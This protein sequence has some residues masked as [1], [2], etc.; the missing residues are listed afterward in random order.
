M[1]E[2]A[3]DAQR[4]G[5]RAVIVIAA[6]AIGFGVVV[7]V[8]YL[9]TAGDLSMAEV[10][11]WDL[12]RR[13]LG[14][15]VS[16]LSVPS[17]TVMT[18]RYH[19]GL[20]YHVALNGWMVFGQSELALRSFTALAG[21]GVLG[22][23]AWVSRRA[24][25]TVAAML[26]ALAA[27][28]PYLVHWSVPA[29]CYGL[30][31]L[32]TVA[33]TA[34]LLAMLRHRRWAW[35]YAGTTILLLHTHHWGSLL[36]AAQSA[37]F[38]VWWLGRLVRPAPWKSWIVC[39]A[40]C[41]VSL[42]PVWGMLELQAETR[43]FG[44]TI[45]FELSTLA[46]WGEELVYLYGRLLQHFDHSNL[47]RHL[48]LDVALSA[49]QAALYLAGLVVAFRRSR[50]L[51]TLALSVLTVPVFL[52]ALLSAIHG[53]RVESIRYFL[54]MAPMGFF[55]WALALDELRRARARFAPGLSAIVLGLLVTTGGCLTI[56]AMTWDTPT[57]YQDLLAGPGDVVRGY[58][59]WKMATDWR[60]L[61]D[62]LKET[63]SGNHVFLVEIG[64][65]AQ[66]LRYYLP[67]ERAIGLFPMR[68]DDPQK[69]LDENLQALGLLFEEVW[70]VRMRP[71]DRQQ[72]QPEAIRKRF[73]AVSTVEFGTVDV[74]HWS[75]NVLGERVGSVGFST[76]FD[77]RPG[78]SQTLEMFLR[79]AD[80][81]SLY[82]AAQA[83]DEPPFVCM[84]DLIANGETVAQEVIGSSYASL[85][86]FDPRLSRG[87]NT[88]EV[89]F[90]PFE[91]DVQ[92]HDTER[93][94]RTNNPTDP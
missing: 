79:G 19:G 8:A 70:Y 88:I 49:I 69:T 64:K 15:M 38:L 35:V 82:V 37:A 55:L 91:G 62:H 77:S 30:Y 65:Q 76:F 13:G 47:V 14:E 22:L 67:G 51:G 60:A 80:R 42:I 4:P 16:R 32:L 46:A 66:Y 74:Q 45:P 57:K 12:A 89:S 73:R 24:G 6:I 93:Y 3:A 48:F 10:L 20:A 29:R 5:R 54:F 7:R 78:A 26:V 25:T 87:S 18:V 83:A 58:E 90:V 41:A 50:V 61:A 72:M 84:L 59:P 27:T 44:S 68:T 63:S 81:R 34:S 33:S 43:G 2:T 11:S 94:R 36:L 1:S 9:C 28:S 56:Q 40:A 92:P 53:V 17:H 85:F 21:I 39:L 86:R 31:L 23:L 71:A 52:H 75:D